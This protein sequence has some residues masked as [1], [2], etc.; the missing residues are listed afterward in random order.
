MNRNA[1]LQRLEARGDNIFGM[2]LGTGVYYKYAVINDMDLAFLFSASRFRQMGMNSLAA[3]MPYGNAND[4]VMNFTRREILP[5]NP[6]I[7]LIFGLCATDPTINLRNYITKL[8]KLNI[9]GICNMPSVIIVD[10]VLSD[11][12][13]AEGFSYEKEI[14]AVRIAHEIDMFTVAMVRDEEQA[15]KMIAVGCDAICVHFGAAKGGVLGAKLEITQREAAQ[16]ATRIFALCDASG[17]KILKLFYGGPARTPPSVRYIKEN[18]HADGF[19]G[20]YSIERLLVEANMRQAW[21]RKTFLGIEEPKGESEKVDYVE[22]TKEYIEKNYREPI[23]ANQIA[24]QLHISRPYF[25]A[26]I[27]K[28][29]GEPFREYLISYRMEKAANL[30]ANTAL[31]ISEIAEAVGYADYM[32]FSKSFKKKMKISPGQYR[33][34]YKNT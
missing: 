9:A 18:A 11:A 23:T 6:K 1:V 27:A 8:K 24:Q 20:G 22:Y 25:S 15:A 7:P 13:E 33:K 17:R 26:M 34:Q 21:L 28:E 2:T 19:V 4:I 14:E 30:L 31:S 29:L 32:H 10:G 5:Q 16:T 12:M 3:T